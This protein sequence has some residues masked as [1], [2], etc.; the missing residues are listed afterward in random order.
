VLDAGGCG[1]GVYG[2]SGLI[3]V[4]PNALSPGVIVSK[5][6][7]LCVIGREAFVA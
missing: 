7:G 2:L 4:H 6:F 3:G 1:P 5:L